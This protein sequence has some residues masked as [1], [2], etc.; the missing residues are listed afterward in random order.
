MASYRPVPASPSVSKWL[1]VPRRNPAASVRLICFASAGL[2]PAMFR[3][4]GPLL[5]PT[6]ELAMVHLP[7]RESRWGERCF[8]QMEDLAPC[9]A[10]AL[11]GSRD[12]PIAVFGHS[13]GAL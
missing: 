13:L 2:G 3:A 12:R 6:I 7:G 1:V 4:W 10:E 11:A 9:I 8:T 5:P